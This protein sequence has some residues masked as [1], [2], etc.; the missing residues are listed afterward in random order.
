MRLPVPW[1]H[2]WS[3]AWPLRRVLVTGPSMVPT[4]RHGDQLLVW[5]SVAGTARG[6]GAPVVVVLPDGTMAVKRLVRCEPDG[7]VWVEGDNPFGSSDS[8]VFG[9]LPAAAVR[10]RVLLRLWPRPGR[11]PALTRRAS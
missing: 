9:A 5:W 11:L 1:P 6:T 2:S 7:R 10:G 8:R 4:L 3:L